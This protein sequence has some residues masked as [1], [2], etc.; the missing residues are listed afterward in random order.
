MSA[1]NIVSGADG[2]TKLTV[3][4]TSK[5]ANATLYDYN[6]REVVLTPT[7]GSFVTQVLIRQ[8]AATAATANQWQMFN[9]STATLVRI[10]AIRLV[11]I[12]DG[13]SPGAQ[14]RNYHIFR[15]SG[16]A[17]TAGTAILPTKKRTAD[18][19]SVCD[20]RFLDTGLTVTGN[21]RNGDEMFRMNLTLDA[22]GRYQAF[23][24]PREFP[25]R[26]LTSAIE[27]RPGEGLGIFNTDATVIGQ[28]ICGYVEWDET[29]L[30]S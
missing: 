14:G 12:F 17:P 18:A 19:A 15:T 27:L 29:A 11:F 24:F 16:V 3:G 25:L 6:G 30:A 2:T 1:A 7:V 4:A 21:T 9:S 5:A 23:F 26:R 8:T 28:G 10:R 13:T 22:T 20:V